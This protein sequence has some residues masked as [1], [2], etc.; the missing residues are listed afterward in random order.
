[1]A[2]VCPG[3]TSTGP[4]GEALCTDGLGTPVAWTV[5]AMFDPSVV[6]TAEWAV[7]FTF[8]FGVVVTAWLMAW[9]VGAILRGIRQF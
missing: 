3:V 7:P 5:E 4:S 9:A 1:V 6:T 2:I 8:G